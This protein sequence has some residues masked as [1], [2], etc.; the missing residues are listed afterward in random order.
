MSIKKSLLASAAV[1]ATIATPVFAQEGEAPRPAAE[2]S[3]AG[4]DIVVT[5]SRIRRQDLAGVGP[6][7]V[8]SA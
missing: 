1:V 7:T 3:D 4:S 2:A 6:A 8:V 5:G